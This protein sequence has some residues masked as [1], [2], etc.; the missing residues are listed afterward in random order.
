M[1]QTI[2]KTQNYNL[3]PYQ[4]S[5]NNI[6]E[7]TQIKDDVW[8]TQKQMAQL[9]DVQKPAICKHIKNIYKQGELDKKQ[10]CQPVS[11]LE[12][13]N[14]RNALGQFSAENYYNL[15]MIISVG[16]RVNSKRG[17]LFRQWAT[18]IIKD[19]IKQ[20]YEQHK[21]H[22]NTSV[23]KI[24]TEKKER[25]KLIKDLLF[26]KGITQKQIGIETGFSFVTVCKFINGKCFNRIIEK[27]IEENLFA[28]EEHNFI[29]NAKEQFNQALQGNFEAYKK[30]LNVLD[31]VAAIN[32]F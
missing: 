12:T 23:P 4:V 11:I 5:N 17:V 30:V 32:N 29:S 18:K 6:I 3:V 27:W 28:C 24:S 26:K 15:D 10:T 7:V 1:T 13:S 25:A 16:Y 22:K 9:F 8:L 19:R 21:Q 14:N 31:T 2:Q 20:E